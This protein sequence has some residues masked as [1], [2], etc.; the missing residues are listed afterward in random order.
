MRTPQRY[1]TTKRLDAFEEE[2]FDVPQGAPM[3]CEFK[4]VTKVK[5]N[6]N[7]HLLPQPRPIQNLVSL[8]VTVSDQQPKPLTISA[9]QQVQP[10]LHTSRSVKL[11]NK[12]EK[13]SYELSQVKTIL[14]PLQTIAEQQHRQPVKKDSGENY[15]F[16]GGNWVGT[17]FQK[18]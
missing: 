15:N 7:R 17:H 5:V 12:I 3:Q 1:E 11:D 18:P 2:D 13:L 10:T 16:I 8:G 6:I 4:V 14:E 9:P